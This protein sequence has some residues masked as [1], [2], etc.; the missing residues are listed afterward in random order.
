LKNIVGEVDGKIEQFRT[1]LFR[2][3]DDFLAHA[4]VI[5]EVAVLEAG[6]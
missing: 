3:R 2:L 6:E 5:T 4:A 1:K